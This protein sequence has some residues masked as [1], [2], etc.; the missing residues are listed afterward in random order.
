MLPSSK[1]DLIKG[2]S[3]FKTG[4]VVGI[5]IIEV[6]GTPVTMSLINASTSSVFHS[7][8]APITAIL[9]IAAIHLRWLFSF[10]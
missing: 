5:G 3:P 9:V 6:R 8:T 10:S 1:G 4:E 7:S 2:A